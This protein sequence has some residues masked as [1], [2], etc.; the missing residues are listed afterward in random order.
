M[1]R[2]G[3][4][5]PGTARRLG[6]EEELRLARAIAT[7]TAIVEEHAPRA[8]GATR[9]IRL[10]RDAL[11]VEAEAPIVAQE[12][13]I[14]QGDLLGAFA[15]APGG[16]SVGTLRIQVARAGGSGRG[17]RPFSPDDE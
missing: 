8:A 11:V 6:L 9:L 4:L 5:I 10:E 13:R 15:T 17:T 16:A 7:W 2:I 14:R 1:E 12:L 3:D